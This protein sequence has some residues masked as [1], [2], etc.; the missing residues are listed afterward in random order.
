MGAVHAGAQRRQRRRRLLGLLLP[1]LRALV[2]AVAL[3]QVVEAKVFDLVAALARHATLRA[4]VAL[5]L[6]LVFEAKE[7]QLGLGL[8]LLG[9]CL[10]G[11]VPSGED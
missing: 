1:G 3:A 10:R 6:L 11:S 4:F 7:L 8:G 2:V 5:L 9:L